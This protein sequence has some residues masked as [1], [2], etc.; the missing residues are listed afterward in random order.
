L[1]S[2]SVALV[3]GANR[4]IGL[5][6]A[7]DLASKGLKVLV[8]ARKL[9]AGVTAARAVGADAQ[10]IQLDVT[11]RASIAAAARQIDDKLVNN[12]GIPHPVRP[13]ASLQEMIQSGQ[14]SGISIDAMRV[15]FETNVFGV[16]AV[17][18]A[19]LP[20]LLKAPAGRIVNIASVTGSL[21]MKAD[22]SSPWHH[23]VG[24]YQAS[25]TARRL[26]AVREGNP[27]FAAVDD[28]KAA[29]VAVFPGLRHCNATP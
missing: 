7:K 22:P 6:I 21:A 16:V 3:T 23:Q 18:Q 17:T 15:V 10:G 27:S 12:A 2:T 26:P 9:D 20:L 19:M 24:V 14:V 5:Q 25:K 1:H 28:S 13:G 29:A 4:G 11:D 8:G